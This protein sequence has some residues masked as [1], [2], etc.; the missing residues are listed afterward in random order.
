MG[1]ST[2]SFEWCSRSVYNEFYFD[3]RAQASNE[4]RFDG[5]IDSINFTRQ[6][7]YESVSKIEVVIIRFDEMKRAAAPIQQRCRYGGSREFSQVD[8]GIAI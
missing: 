5:E 7:E 6:S 4:K 3:L 2:A 1:D 8:M